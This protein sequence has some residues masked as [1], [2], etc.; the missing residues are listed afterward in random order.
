M[1]LLDVNMQYASYM[2]NL[3]ENFQQQQQQTKMIFLSIEAPEL[4]F[5]HL[6]RAIGAGRRI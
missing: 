2:D 1:L 5:S 3:W 6:I 4:T